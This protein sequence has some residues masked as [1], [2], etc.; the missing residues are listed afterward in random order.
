MLIRKQNSSHKKIKIR[1]LSCVFFV[2]L[3]CVIPVTRNAIRYCVVAVTMPIVRASHA[4]EEKAYSFTQ[5]FRFKSSLVEEN[6][7]LS[8]E[9][10]NLNSRFADYD[11]LVQEN[12]DLKLTM[13]R[14][15][16]MDFVLAVILSKPPT[17]AYDTLL[18]D[19]GEAL[20]MQVG[21]SVYANGNIPIGTIAQVFANSALVELYSSPSEKID[22]RLDPS[23]IDV[24]LFGHGG[25][26]LLVS[27]PHD[28]TVPENSIVVSKEINPHVLGRLEKIISD[29]RD[30]SQTLIFSAPININELDF[31]EVAK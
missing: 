6:T 4:A 14:S 26:D 25:G 9:I 22:A 27:V 15:G 8:R 1:I 16:G 23:H 7:Q 10:Q 17:S 13:G 28:L 31:V 21:Q 12:Q 20:Q 24:T 2:F 11:E 3:L 5:T 18:I 29:P 19:G 30:S